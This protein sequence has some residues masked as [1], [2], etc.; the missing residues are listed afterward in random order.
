MAPTEY[1]WP[2]GDAMI[3]SKSNFPFLDKIMCDSHTEEETVASV[4]AA[5]AAAA[6]GRQGVMHLSYDPCVV[7]AWP[8][9]A[10][11]CQ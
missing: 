6:A 7:S 9:L 3:R 8:A 11:C 10:N 2:L 5:A 4:V 1:H